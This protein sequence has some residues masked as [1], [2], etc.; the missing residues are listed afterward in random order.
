MPV[1]LP[2]HERVA[3]VPDVEKPA[4]QLHVV[5][6][7]ELTLLAGHAEH[8]EAPATALYEFAAHTVVS[9]PIQGAPP[10]QQKCQFSKL[11]REVVVHTC[12]H[13]PVHASDAPEP[14][15]E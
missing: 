15:D 3:P 2:E 4:L 1:Q 14:E 10:W 9:G 8:V 6:P 5:A 11:S 13:A 7:A 12:A